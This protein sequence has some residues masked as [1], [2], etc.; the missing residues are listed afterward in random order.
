MT[1]VVILVVALVFTVGFA[2]LTLNE[3]AQ[4]GLGV[5]SLL[6][7]LVIAL[8]GVGIVGALRHPPP[9]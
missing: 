2:A 4:E 8:L 7:L 6:S 9:E 5:G 1:R 3:V